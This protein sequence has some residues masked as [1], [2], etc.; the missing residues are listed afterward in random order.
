MATLLQPGPDEKAQAAVQSAQLRAN[1]LTTQGQMKAAGHK[2]DA[3]LT[4]EDAARNREHDKEMLA[5]KMKMELIQYAQK[6]GIDLRV[7]QQE[8]EAVKIPEMAVSANL[9]TGEATNAT[10]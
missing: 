7:A 4:A 2:L 3:I 6:K 8:L 5:M 10:A 9:A 1:A